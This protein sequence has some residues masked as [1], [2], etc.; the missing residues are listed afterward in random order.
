MTFCLFLKMDKKKSGSALHI[1]G[2]HGQAQSY[3]QQTLTALDKKK[4]KLKELQRKKKGW[5]KKSWP[6]TAEEVELFFALIDIKVMSRVLKMT[7]ISKEQLLWCEEKMSKLD[8]S[9]SKLQRNGSP[10]LFPC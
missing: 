6:P 5:K 10:L 8:F 3:L 4:I 1:F 9:G 7:K 2:A